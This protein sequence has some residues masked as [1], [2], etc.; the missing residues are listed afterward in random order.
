MRSTLARRR[1]SALVSGSGLGGPGCLD[2]LVVAA[3]HDGATAFP[4]G[5]AL[6]QRA[7][8]AGGCVEAERPA[9]RPLWSLAGRASVVVLPAGQVTLPASGRCE[10]GLREATAVG[11]RAAPWP[12][13]RPP[14]PRPLH[15]RPRRSTPCRPA[16]CRSRCPRS[17]DLST[18]GPPPR[19]RRRCRPARR[20]PGPA[21]CPRRSSRRACGRQSDAR[22]T[23][24]R[25]A[26][27]DR[28][29]RSPG[30]WPLPG[31]S[32]ARPRRR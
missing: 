25:G 14:P 13:S 1:S 8:G 23:C 3:H 31:G 11:R 22:P 20:R 18:A 9:R 28:R 19:R 16:G 32:P 29:A 5:A 2:A 12:P 30:R 7:G 15:A 24:G 4:G 10:I 26:S 27:P 17:L 21:R 6:P